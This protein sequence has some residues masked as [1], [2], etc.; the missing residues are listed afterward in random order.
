MTIHQSVEMALARS[1]FWKFLLQFG[2]ENQIDLVSAHETSPYFVAKTF[3]LLAGTPA[4]LTRPFFQKY[5]FLCSF[6]VKIKEIYTLP[7]DF[8]NAALIIFNSPN[9]VLPRLFV[10]FSS[11]NTLERNSTVGFSSPSSSTYIPTAQRSLGVSIK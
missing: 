3:P 9:L 10:R 6:V 5:L 4:L 11:A 8:Q 2:S 7:R 1:P